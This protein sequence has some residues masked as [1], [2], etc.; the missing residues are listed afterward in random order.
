MC[1]C[2]L[3]PLELRREKGRGNMLFG[4]RG[5]RNVHIGIFFGGGRGGGKEEDCCFVVCVFN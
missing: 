5:R 1:S 4:K 2:R 3:G